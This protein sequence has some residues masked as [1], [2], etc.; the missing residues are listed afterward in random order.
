MDENLLL[1]IGQILLA[2]TFGSA[3]Y[4]H[5]IG[6]EQS[7][8]QPRTTWLAA[9]GRDRMRI[10]AALELLG[11]I[12]LVL[13]AATGILPWLTPAAAMCLAVLMAFAIVF[14]APREGEGRNIVLNAILGVM[15]ALIA[16]GRFVVAPL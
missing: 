8:S 14:H 12:G 7:S 6:F 10:I 5:S 4:R 9:V 11:A 13:P 2:L 3:A 15:A 16:Y 1:W